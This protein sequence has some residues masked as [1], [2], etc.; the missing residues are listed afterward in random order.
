M[1]GK[2]TVS[3]FSL[4]STNFFLCIT[5]LGSK[6]LTFITFSIKSNGITIITNAIQAK[7]MI[8]LTFFLSFL[9]CITNNF[10]KNLLLNLTEK[11]N[12]LEVFAH[13]SNIEEAIGFQ[14]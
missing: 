2:F 1:F 3:P 9:W 8:S 10:F 7:K 12:K 11:S 6:Y 5:N 14:R 4:K 13:F